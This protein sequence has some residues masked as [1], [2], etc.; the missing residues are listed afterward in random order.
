[1]RSSGQA[2]RVAPEA[3]LAAEGKVRGP[4]CPQAANSKVDATTRTLKITWT[5]RRACAATLVATIQS[6][7]PSRIFG[8]RSAHREP[9]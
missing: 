2:H 7:L 9:A 8:D 5:W 1:M 6:I 4:F 3:A